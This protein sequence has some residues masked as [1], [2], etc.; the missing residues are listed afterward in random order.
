[1]LRVALRLDAAASGALGLLALAA[2]PLLES[3]LGVPGALLMP[4]GAALLVWA[5]GLALAASRPTIS[6]PAAW[7]VIGLN[8][9]WVAASAAAVAAGWLPLTA[10]G[11]AFV[12]AQAVAVAAFA[13]LQFLGL[14]RA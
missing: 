1:M 4:V 5:S 6:R 14:R 9:L 2:A 7:S 10:L 8:V 13:D 11:T 12:L 3:R